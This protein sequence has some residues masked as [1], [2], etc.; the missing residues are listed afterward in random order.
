GGYY[1][2]PGE[3]LFHRR[4]VKWLDITIDRQEMSE[5]LRNS[6]GSIGTVSKVSKYA[7]ELESLLGGVAPPALIASDA[8]VE[9]PSVFALEAHLEEFLVKNWQQTDLGRNYDIFEDEGEL[10]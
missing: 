7:E 6:S 9:D 5:A 10:I 3:T 4:P 2:Q 1:Y 8:N